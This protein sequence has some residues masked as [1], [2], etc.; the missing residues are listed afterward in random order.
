MIGDGVQKCTAMEKEVS[1]EKSVEPVVKGVAGSAMETKETA[2]V[3]SGEGIEQMSLEDIC[4]LI[5]ENIRLKQELRIRDNDILSHDQVFDS[6][7]SGTLHLILV[8]SVTTFEA[9]FVTANI[10]TALGIG[11]KEAMEDVRRIGDV[12]EKIELFNGKE[13]AF[14]H[15]KN[16]ARRQFLIYVIHL[17]YGRSDRVAVVLLCKSNAARDDDPADAGRQ[18]R[19][20]IFSCQH[21]P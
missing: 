5:E 15:R 16:G 19:R 7:V 8:M 12:F 1:V 4:A 6:I 14:V 2:S 21:V 9:E 17:P 20:G 18:P 10:D 13:V 11:R 3:L